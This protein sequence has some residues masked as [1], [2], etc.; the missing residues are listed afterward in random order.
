[1]GGCLRSQNMVRL[2]FNARRQTLACGRKLKGIVWFATAINT[3]SIRLRNDKRLT[4]RSI[5]FSVKCS[6]MRWICFEERSNKKHFVIWLWMFNHIEYLVFLQ[7]LIIIIHA[8]GTGTI[9]SLR[10]S[11]HYYYLPTSFLGYI[12]SICNWPQITLNSNRL[13]GYD[14]A[15][16]ILRAFSICFVFVRI[17][18]KWCEK[19][20][21]VVA[22]NINLRT[23]LRVALRWRM[24]MANSGHH[25]SFR[26]LKMLCVFF[27]V[28]EDLSHAQ[29]HALNLLRIVDANDFRTCE[30]TFWRSC[31][32]FDAHRHGTG[33]NRIEE[34]A[35]SREEEGKN[36]RNGQQNIFANLEF[37]CFL[38]L[39]INKIEL[40]KFAFY[41]KI[42]LSLRDGK[43]ILETTKT[44][45][46]KKK[47]HKR[48]MIS[49][50]SIDF[51][52][53][54]ATW[55]WRAA[56][57]TTPPSTR[58]ILDANVNLI[59]EQ[60]THSHWEWEKI[61][62]VVI[63]IIALSQAAISRMFCS[64]SFQ[65]FSD[66]LYIFSV[67]FAGWAYKSIV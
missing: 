17:D 26:L 36:T 44:M 23:G 29:A 31:S 59:H 67:D 30:S 56:A 46:T 55:R 19:F 47:N 39:K 24:S 41:W 54:H 11:S 34:E 25:V 3:D 32:W 58:R 65:C 35:Q 4:Q 12:L 7:F 48:N 18:K 43:L 1:M 22:V 16:A 9:T 63:F 28:E 42:M 52:V 38:R 15:S 49:S 27:I 6:T 66:Y 60:Q 45:R 40:E 62:R 21:L 57:T 13:I 33:V 14:F 2:R 5:A 37:R 10:I 8:P 53:V 50:A 64:V 20:R 61:E 51:S